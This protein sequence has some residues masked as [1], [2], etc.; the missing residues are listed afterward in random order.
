MLCIFYD[1]N[2]EKMHRSS[3]PHYHTERCM[4]TPVCSWADMVSLDFHGKDSPFVTLSFYSSNL[5][6]SHFGM[7]RLCLVSRSLYLR[8]QL[9][10]GVMWTNEFL[11]IQRYLGAQGKFIWLQPHLPREEL[12][13]LLFLEE[14]QTMAAVTHCLVHPERVP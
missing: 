6:A 5:K 13:K 9:L 1:N 12:S 7:N 3:F 8:Y 14:G 2:F 4:A 11:S 10:I